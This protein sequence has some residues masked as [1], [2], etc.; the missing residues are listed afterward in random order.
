MHADDG[1]DMGGR[2]IG[3]ISTFTLQVADPAST[4]TV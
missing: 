4:F 2:F 1:G 3:G